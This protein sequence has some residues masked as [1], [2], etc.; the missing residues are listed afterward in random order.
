MAES[1]QTPTEQVEQSLPYQEVIPNEVTQAV[2]DTEQSITASA[3][4]M[5]AARERAAFETYVQTSGEGIP[6][7]FADAG[8]WFDSLKMAQ[9]NYTQGQQ[10]ISDLKRQYAETGPVNENPVTPE[11]PSGA[12]TEALAKPGDAE[13]RI[14][15]KAEEVTKETTEV[16]QDM[17]GVGQGDWDN[18]SYEVAATGTLSED[19]RTK[20]SHKTGLNESMIDD[21]LTG[22]KAKMRESY[23][24]AGTIVGG[25]DR[26]QN[27][28]QWASETLSEDVQYSINA[29][30]ST[31]NMRDI[32]LRGLAA[33]FDA[34]ESAKPG[35]NE[36]A[37]TQN[38]VN[39]TATQQ[40]YTTYTTRREFLTDRNNPRFKIEPK[41]REVVEQRMMRT[42]W[43]TLPE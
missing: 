32:T 22:Q 41:F 38:R 18:W 3:D 43:N 17:L 8:S 27:M 42:D 6:E 29:G 23:T 35:N 31:P 13:L 21:F 25:I 39:Q 11:N 14:P 33:K 37:P 9:K 7:N 5:N 26:L 28:L 36:P 12:P 24:Q 15:A 2:R 10:E 19:T 34:A 30:M 1:N 4:E 16:S 40:T 20:I